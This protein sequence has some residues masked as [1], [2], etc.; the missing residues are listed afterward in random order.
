MPRVLP[1]AGL[2]Y[3]ARPDE[4]ERLI[5]PPYD[6]IS[7]EEQ[8]RLTQLSANNAVYV[9]LPQ[10]ENGLPG[11]RY[12]S[13][14]K[15]LATWRKHGVLQPDPR[16]AY[17]LSET[18]FTYAGQ[19]L[20][21]RDLL[22]ALGVEPWSTGDVLPHEHTMA[23]PKADR[24]E[25]LRA[26]HLN[27]S[28]IWVLH[29]EPVAEIDQAWAVA[30]TTPPTVEFTWHDERHRL[31]VVDDPATVSGIRAAFA[32]GGPLYIADGHHRYETSLA[33]RTEAES[34]VA[35]AHETLA[36]VTW[37]EDPGLLALPTHR[38]LHGLDP[39]L[40][41][42]EAEDRW[43]E[44]FHVE[45]YPVWEDAPAEQV[46]ALIVQLASSGRSAPSFG[47]YGLGHLDL[48]GILELR[49]R[50][51]PLGALPAERSD[52][53]KSLDVALLH[54]LL[55]DP[56]AEETGRPRGDVL[57]YVRDP[58]EAVQAVRGGRASAAFFLNPTPV[59]GVLAVADAQDRM[60]EKSTYFH[61]KPP[62]GLV[63]RSLDS[64]G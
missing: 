26:T 43:S 8:A 21:R 20:K 56:L 5:C 42:E 46:D 59:T 15:D 48:F 6:V 61:P 54:T 3:A 13:A 22:A 25:L 38:L 52:A 49:G 53:W 14:A 12:L 63:M 41:L 18:E 35:G 10:D 51:P 19:T 37:A 50:K 60:P 55:V 29:R 11:S 27:A 36:A 24:L 62:A 34:T 39:S 44:P 4:L 40:T 23:G 2:R 1:F 31:W 47:L 30:E 45:Y 16:P 9:E 32:G 7:A 28:P 17:Y 57:T 58:Q 33:F 64:V